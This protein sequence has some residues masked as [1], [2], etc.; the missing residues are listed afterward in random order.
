MITA[1]AAPIIPPT[2]PPS[3]PP[4][5]A[6]GEWLVASVTV[7]GFFVV[8]PEGCELVDWGG[9]WRVDWAVVVGK[10]SFLISQTYPS[11]RPLSLQCTLFHWPLGRISTQDSRGPFGWFGSPKERK[12][13]RRLRKI[14]QLYGTINERTNQSINQSIDPLIQQPISSAINQAINHW[15]V[16]VRY[17]DSSC[18]SWSTRSLHSSSATWNY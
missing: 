15:Q 5:R 11:W 10:G 16:I 13:K 1:M 2:L 4:V 12:V 9:G 3:R 7:S 6:C 8:E 18:P 17:L 14:H